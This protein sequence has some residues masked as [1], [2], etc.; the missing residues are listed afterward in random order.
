MKVILEGESFREEFQLPQELL[1]TIQDVC[2]F[3]AFT[4]P[5]AFRYLLAVGA[6]W[7]EPRL[8]VL[9]TYLREGGLCGDVPKKEE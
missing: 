9:R 1:S 2:A 5:D 6:R 4:P 8:D 3:F 7:V